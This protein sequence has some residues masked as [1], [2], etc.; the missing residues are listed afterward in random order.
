ME[1]SVE[2]IVTSKMA[3]KGGIIVSSI[4]KKIHGPTGQMGNE[5]NKTQKKL[6]TLLKKYYVFQK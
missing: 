4:E 1:N 2:M 3:G 6:T 5:K